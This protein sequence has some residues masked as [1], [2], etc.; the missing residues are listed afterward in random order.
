[1]GQLEQTVVEQHIGSGIAAEV[2]DRS[3]ARSV[4]E[5][6]PAARRERGVVSE[7]AAF[8][9]RGEQRI[10]TG[11]RMGDGANE[12]ASDKFH[13]WLARPGRPARR[14]DE[15]AVRADDLF[16]IALIR[17]QPG[18]GIGDKSATQETEVPNLFAF[19][20]YIYPGAGSTE[21]L[22]PAGIAEVAVEE[23]I[24]LPPNDTQSLASIETRPEPGDPATALA[25]LGAVDNHAIKRMVVAADRRD[26]LGPSIVGKDKT[27]TRELMPGIAERASN[28]HFVDIAVQFDA[29]DFNRCGALTDFDHGVIWG[30]NSLGPVIRAGKGQWL[31]GRLIEDAESKTRRGHQSSA[32]PDNPEW[33][34]KPGEI[35]NRARTQEIASAVSNL[36]SNQI[37]F[38]AF[39]GDRPPA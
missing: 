14:A 16:A 6:Y 20:L 12:R 29:T 7:R 36:F 1:M 3:T 27:A 39:Q 19:G 17:Q 37:C 33:E 32:V 18:A 10:A 35:Q 24:G 34:F 2:C 13:A 8:K 30:A 28:D 31:Q 25:L 38:A 23:V 26:D 22:R 15:R 5:K 4:I 9:A 21:D 11:E